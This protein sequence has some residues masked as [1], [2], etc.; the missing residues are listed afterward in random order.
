M[1]DFKE[2]SSPEVWELFTRDFLADMGFDI[3]SSPDRGADGG[4]DF[5]VSER[6][7]GL[8]SVHRLLTMVSCKHNIFSGKSVKE[9]D[10]QNIL[11]RMKA[12]RADCFIGMYSTLPSAALNTRLQRL[13]DSGQIKSFKV[14]D[15]RLIE[16][17]L[18]EDSNSKLLLR[19]F[20]ESY[21][22]IKPIHNIVDE[23]VPALCE[24]CGE[25]LLKKSVH[26]EYS[27]NVVFAYNRDSEI[28]EKVYCACKGRACDSYL[29]NQLFE[30]GLMTRWI[31]LQDLFIPGRFLQHIL[32]V[33][34]E[35]RDGY[36]KYTDSAW[37]EHR[38]ILIAVAQRVL[39]VTTK[40][41]RD[42]ML[43]LLQLNF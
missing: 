2:I 37:K 5:I 33:M 11:E 10:E 21:S 40:R 4:K 31:D 13:V 14:Y 43:T 35:M 39:R 27:A 17:E 24:I 7:V 28:I 23:Y 32:G 16:K 9:S 18:I 36:D 34:N 6:V 38:D 15:H 26:N 19:Y 1:I 29:E 22:V 12:F 3:V 42:R 41:E 8:A 25:D 20:P 30:K